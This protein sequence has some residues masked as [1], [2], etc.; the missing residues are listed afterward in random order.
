MILVKYNIYSENKNGIRVFIAKRDYGVALY[1][2]ER[3]SDKVGGYENAVE[4]LKDA[5]E[6]K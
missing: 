2:G 1:R 5:R 6:L 3:V 4:A